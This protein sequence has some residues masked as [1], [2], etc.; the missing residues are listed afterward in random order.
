MAIEAAEPLLADHRAELTIVGDGPE[1]AKLEQLAARSA[2]P[3]AIR[4]TGNVP[5]TEVQHY[6]AT[7]DLFVFPSIREF[8]GAVVLEA[9]AMGAVPIVVNYGGPA[10]L[11]T[12]D[13]GTA[14]DVGPRQQIVDELRKSLELV[15]SDPS[16]L[17]PKIAAG[18][19]RVT[20]QFTWEAKARSVVAIYD[21]VLVRGQHAKSGSNAIDGTNSEPTLTGAEPI[22]SSQTATS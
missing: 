22:E 16:S 14:I 19:Q 8:G 13:T 12:G 6:F 11:I 17:L 9:M 20:E 5:H 7:A 15:A 2:N 1:R 10:E 3:T 4:F 18:R 21:K